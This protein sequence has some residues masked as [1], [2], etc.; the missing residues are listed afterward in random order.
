MSSENNPRSPK[1]VRL[2]LLGISAIALLAVATASGAQLKH[3]P[4]HAKVSRSLASTFVSPVHIG[5]TLEGCRNDGSILLPIAGQFICPDAA[6]TTGN[7]GK[8]WNELDLVPFRITT[9]SGNQGT[10]TTSYNLTVAGD[11][12]DGGHVGWDVI[13]VPTIDPSSDASCHV[14]GGATGIGAG[15]AGGNTDSIFE[16]LSIQQN[17]NTTCVF[18]YYMRLAL[19]SHLYSG[20]SLQA[21]LF[22]TGDFSGGQKTV[23]IPVHDILPQS[24][25]K[26]MAAS[27]SDN[28]P[29]MISKNAGAANIPFGD[30][31]SNSFTNTKAVAITVTWTKL[32]KVGTGQVLLATV[33]KATNPA[34]RDIT[35]NVTDILYEGT[36]PT[37]QVGVTA[38]SG[39]IVVPA[40]TANFTVLSDSQ[41]ITS[42]ATHFND[43]ATGSYTDTVANVPIPGTVTAV[44]DAGVNS[45]GTTNGTASIQDSESITGTGLSFAVATPSSGSFDGY[46]AGSYVTGPVIWNSGNFT[47]S[48]SITF[49]KTIKL[50][51]AIATSGILSDTATLTG[52][53]GFTAHDS[54]SVNISS[55]STSTLT[56]HKTIPNV[57]TGNETVT[58]HFHVWSGAND[59]ADPTITFNAGDQNESVD[60]SG[61]AQG[62]YTVK[63]D[64]ATG[65]NPQTDQPVTLNSCTGQVTFNNSFTEATS[66]ATK[67][68]DPAVDATNSNAPYAQ[69]WTFTLT[70]PDA[71]TLT[72]TTDASGHVIW[73]GG[74][75]TTAPLG[76]EGTYTISES[77]QTGWSEVGAVGGGT[78]TVTGSSTSCSFTVNYPADAGKTFNCT[79]SN[80]SRGSIR[81]HKTV[82]GLALSGSQ[83]FMFEVVSGAS[84]ST[85]GTLV[86]SP[87]TATAG[88]VGTVNFTGLKPG[89]PYSLCELM[90]AGF[91]PNWPNGFGP[92]NPADAP[93]WECIDFSFEPADTVNTPA[94]LFNVDNSHA[95]AGALTIGYWKNHAA[96]TCKKSNGKQA[97]V[98]GQY[99]SGITLGAVTFSLTGTWECQGAVQTLSKQTFN[100]VNRA[101]DPLF[102]MAAQL[103]A[104]YLNINSG[105]GTCQA[106]SDAAAS[107]QALLGSYGWNGNTYSPT[108]SSADAATANAD[109]GLLD[110]YNNN[111]LC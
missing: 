85:I 18:N 102:N 68:T 16:T 27:T 12:V 53:D 23:S 58:F 10:T 24:L 98:L 2:A 77:S 9:A 41:T 106:A 72:G 47:D 31:C 25:A 7:L 80:Q 28:Q 103:L 8:G 26:T 99:L 55:Q 95:T 107:G 87:Q 90:V 79:I 5:E 101:S 75:S 111:N 91:G 56:I 70:R 97:D 71:S 43:V 54:A 13:S 44:A 74:S 105:A 62:D 86:G 19:G 92:F 60:V 94:I 48:G 30:V 40:N 14:S 73:T 17:R 64:T 42:T 57:L 37:T 1:R 11:H 36:T 96:A 83:A 76:L 65:W 66:A 49:N 39:D 100:G 21:Y 29:W 109:A 78:G 59:V 32:A 82:N 61:L 108:L 52:A 22:E 84:V 3:S 89:T 50:D 46:T 51:P 4:H 33:I 104:Y 15:L 45:T 6:Y 93:N 35:V 110:T 81:V 34:A 63:E 20:S 38:H 67:A 69:G 88:N